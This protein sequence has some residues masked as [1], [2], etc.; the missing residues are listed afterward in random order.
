ML[1]INLF[2]IYR[3]KQ[4][5]CATSILLNQRRWYLVQKIHSSFTK[6][7]CQICT[8]PLTDDDRV[9]DHC[10]ITG[11]YR[12][13][14]HSP[15]NLNYRITTKSW[16]LPVVI[17]NLKGY[18]GH[19]IVKALKSEFGRVR[20]VPQNLEKYLSLTVGQ[21]KFLDTF[22][23]TTKSFFLSKTLEDDEVK[24]LLESCTTSHFDIVRR[25][26]VSPYDYMDSFERFDESQQTIWQLVLRI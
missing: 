3:E 9:R 10:H 4:S 23:F 5:S 16:K 12:G 26:G 6:A 20:V 22:Q 14:A 25:K 24:Y 19:L 15:C 7:T 1:P 13:A 18:D 17:H 8:K 2:V 11:I 21:L